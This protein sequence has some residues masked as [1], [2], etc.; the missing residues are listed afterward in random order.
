MRNRIYSSDEGD[1]MDGET[2]LPCRGTIDD[3]QLRKAFNH[4][5]ASDDNNVLQMALQL[6]A[7]TER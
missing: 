3:S 7:M 6:F 5:L 4:A 2:Y 1:E